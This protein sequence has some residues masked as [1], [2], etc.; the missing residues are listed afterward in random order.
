MP[1]CTH[2]PFRSYISPSWRRCNTRDC[3]RAAASTSRRA[4]VV[5]AGRPSCTAGELEEEEEENMGELEAPLRPNRT[6]PPAG[7]YLTVHITRLMC[8]S[9]LTNSQPFLHST[10][11]LSR[12]AEKVEARCL[13]RRRSTRGRA[14]AR[15][16]SRA[17]LRRKESA[18]GSVMAT[19]RDHGKPF[20]SKTPV[21]FV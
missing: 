13:A 21:V 2:L 10:C 20:L 12:V 17:S 8:S 11:T 14:R 15:G 4:A 7:R 1:R 19:V 18:M 6:F 5:G 9:I 3:L 16:R